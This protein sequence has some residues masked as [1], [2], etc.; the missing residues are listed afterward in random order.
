MTSK[1]DQRGAHLAEIG[2]AVITITFTE[3]EAVV[4][5]LPPQFRCSTHRFSSKGGYQAMK[6]CRNNVASQGAGAMGAVWPAR[7][8][9]AVPPRE[10]L[11]R[12]ARRRASPRIDGV[13]RPSDVTSLI[14]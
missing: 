9:P 10:A 1:Y 14:A 4:G 5:P 8:S 6:K 11:T 7:R 3:V 13:A 2:A 12:S